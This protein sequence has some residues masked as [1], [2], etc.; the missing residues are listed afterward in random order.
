MRLGRAGRDGGA[1]LSAAGGPRS[2]VIA[3]LDPVILEAAR[4]WI[5]IHDPVE[6]LEHALI[7][8]AWPDPALDF[9]IENRGALGPDHIS[10]SADL[11][12]VLRRLK[13][14][15]RRRALARR[16]RRS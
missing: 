5:G 9:L 3:E 6:L 8:L 7:P 11:A 2:R 16:P 13:P 4:E 14:G 12:S 1:A 15:R 10:T